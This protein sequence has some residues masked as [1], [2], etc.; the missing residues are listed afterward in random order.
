MNTGTTKK[1]KNLD[2]CLKNEGIL[3]NGFGIAPK[4]VMRDR[5]ISA[6]AKA[7]YCYFQSFAGSSGKAFPKRETILADL[8]M[9]KD[10][11]YKHLK[12]LTDLD[13]IRLE[14][15]G[16]QA[17]KGRNIYVIVSN[18]KGL[19]NEISRHNA[20]V[21]PDPPICMEEPQKAPDHHKA[22]RAV[23]PA[24]HTPARE[25]KKD[26]IHK[27]LGIAKLIE[28]HP[29]HENHIRHIYHAVLDM[30]D[31][32]IIKI[33]GTVRNNESIMAMVKEMDE[34]NVLYALSA[35]LQH[36]DK[37]KNKRAWI[38]ACLLNS[39]FEDADAME[40]SI[41]YV[42]RL[43]KQAQGMAEEQDA[44]TRSHNGDESDPYL[45]E[46]KKTINSLFCQMLH[47]KLAGDNTL[48]KQCRDIIEQI[49]EEIEKHKN[50]RNN[51][52]VR[53]GNTAALV[54]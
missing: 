20:K 24:K 50:R 21:L 2:V 14:K 46:K 16:E 36:K 23:R 53:N 11:Y 39:I 44:A 1:E 9:S 8:G 29:E 4:T 27:A 13:Y 52:D 37:I 15:S 48:V 18:P 5:R 26:G 40:K 51:F 47:A 54:L 31:A 7:I 45:E 30:M 38:Q 35:F 28:Q 49:D 12:Q 32:P 17:L 19:G 25:N 33:S 6:E 22:H 41:A 43:S 34:R 10:R 3:S 42:T